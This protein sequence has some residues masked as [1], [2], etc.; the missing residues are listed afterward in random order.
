MPSETLASTTLS[1]NNAADLFITFALLGYDAGEEQLFEFTHAE[2]TSIT[3]L[4]II[5]RREA[6]TVSRGK[7]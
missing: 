4:Y 5:E 2:A 6:N 3:Q 7:A 1:I